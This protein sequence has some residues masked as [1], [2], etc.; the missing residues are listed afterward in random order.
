[1]SNNMNELKQESFRLGRQYYKQH[2]TYQRGTVQAEFLRGVMFQE[3]ISK[4]AFEGKVWNQSGKCKS[5]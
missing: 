2:S 5:L 3:R 4:C 1:M